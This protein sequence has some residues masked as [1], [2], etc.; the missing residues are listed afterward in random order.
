MTAVKKADLSVKGFGELSLDEQQ[1]V[2]GG[3]WSSWA[4]GALIGTVLVGGLFG[5]PV[6]LV[7]AGIAGYELATQ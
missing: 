2:R 4:T 7:A 1:T 3:D 5:A 6:L